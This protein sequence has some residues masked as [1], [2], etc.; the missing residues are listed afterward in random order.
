M[1][2]LIAEN[3]VWRNLTILLTWQKNAPLS[4][5]RRSHVGGLSD[6]NLTLWRN[7]TLFGISK[8]TFFQNSQKNP[9]CNIQSACNKNF[10]Q[11]PAKFYCR[12][13]CNLSKNFN[14]AYM[15]L[16][17]G[18]IFFRGLSQLPGIQDR[19]LDSHGNDPVSHVIKHFL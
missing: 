19:N 2:I 6:K 4:L 15:D 14:C 1:L 7:Q 13:H 10:I 3:M 12:V 18:M 11:W 17:V 8:N 9:C 5:I 16:H